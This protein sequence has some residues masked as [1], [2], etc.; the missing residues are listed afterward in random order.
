MDTMKIKK[1]IATLMI[2]TICPTILLAQPKGK[3]KPSKDKVKAMKVAYITEKLDLSTK[4]AQQFWPIY[5]EFD[6]KME[7]THKELRKMHRQEKS[8]DDMT[9]SEVD[10]MLNK[11]TEL[12]QKEFIIE[13]EY[14]QKFKK[15]LPIKKIAKLYRAEHDFKRDLLKKIKNHQGGPPPPRH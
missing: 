12:R 13:K 9:D 6:G 11:H 14:H 15:V 10:K 3:G 8:I 7:A 5:N 4:E 1:L 2:I